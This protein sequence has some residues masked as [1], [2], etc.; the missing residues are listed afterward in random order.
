MPHYNSALVYL[1]GIGLLISASGA[2]ATSS[3]PAAGA[4][5]DLAAYVNPFVGTCGDGNTY[6]GAVAPFGMIQLSPDTDLEAW[7]AASGY[8][9][10]DETIIG[11]SLTHLNGTG[12]PDL[13]DILFMPSVGVLKFEPGTKE[14][15]AVGYR[16]SFDHDH[17][18]ATPGYYSVHLP[19]DDIEVELAAADRSGI[20]QFTFAASDSANIMVDLNHVLQW[21]V[22]WT[23]V[24]FEDGNLITGYHQVNGW[25]KERYVYFAARY[26]RPCDDFGIM[27]DGEKVVYNTNRFRSARTAAGRNIQ[28][29]TTYK[30]DP[31]EQIIV[32]VGISPVSTANAL[33]NLDAE[34]P[35][36][37]LPK[38]VAETRQKWND[39]LGIFS[40]EGTQT[41]KETF[42]TSVY[43]AFL[44]PTL[45]EDV[46]GQYRGFDQNV[47][48]SDGFTNHAIFSLWDTYRAIHPL[49]C[50]VQPRR[51]ADMINSMLAHYDQSV[52]HL[53]P[54][55]SLNNNET[56]CMIGYHSV[57]VIADA[58]LKGVTGFDPERAYAAVKTTAMSPDYDSVKAY[59]EL[60]YVPFD[61]ENESV[62]KTL[63]YAYDDYCVARMA[64]ALGKDD[65]YDYFR[66]RSQSYRNLVDPVSH[67]MRGRDSSGHWRT[68]FAPDFFAYWWDFTEGTSWQYSWYVPQDVDGLIDAMGG[69]E[70]FTA[71]LDSL[72]SAQPSDEGEGIND[73][74]GRIGQYWHGNEPSHHI[75]YLYN[76]VGRPWRTQE[77]VHQIM[78]TQYG[79]QPGSLC[80]ND[81]CGQMSAWYIFNA[82][83]FYPVCPG[84]DFY[85]IGSPCLPKVVMRL[86]SGKELVVK[87]LNLDDE[88]IYIQGVKLNGQD[89]H[90][91]E[92]PFGAIADGGELIF[93]MS[94][95]PNRNWMR[96]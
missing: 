53:L 31:G 92:I 9:Y 61:E 21:N 22:I 26:S 50:L 44:A 15:P 71:K 1:L 5:P 88:N 95:R 38:L 23:N 42:Y 77:L 34:I 93:D 91:T 43:H 3:E 14:A 84:S 27:L 46:N 72:F 52:D 20:L 82:M 32:K 75:S 94:P 65:D 68:P 13:G 80:G 76:W 54:E 67:F 51:N 45:Y 8:E 11:F 74:Q 55:W 41:E 85:S 40:I 10:T 70:P 59:S 7:G 62:S 12:I 83:G 28:F 39:E 57:S 29:Y 64:Q 47:H 30:T 86:A 69:A 18:S 90:Q 63:E 79:N 25:A 33:A 48:Q 78:K 35:G 87:A 17:E 6:P 73:I 24:R 96:D 49:F 81:D 56:W 19:E 89:W 58:Y 36:W 2:T 4:A 60:G 37:D 16:T 66:Q